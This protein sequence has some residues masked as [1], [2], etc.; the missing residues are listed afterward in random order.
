MS[1]VAGRSTTAEHEPPNRAAREMT[2]QSL[3]RG[4]SADVSAVLSRRGA[5]TRV[6]CAR[7]NLARAHLERIGLLRPVAPWTV[8][9]HERAAGGPAGAAIRFGERSDGSSD[10]GSSDK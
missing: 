9:T 6:G 4:R 10:D 1:Q 7:I 2:R 5:V 3:Q 8:G